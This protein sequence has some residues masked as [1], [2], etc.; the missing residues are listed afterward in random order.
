MKRVWQCD[1][2]SRTNENSENIL[3]HEKT[4]SYNPIMKKCYSCVH[5]G[6]EGYDYPIPT[7]DIKLDV[8]DGEEYGNCKGWSPSNIKEWRKIKLENLK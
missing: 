5:R 7:C 6:D 3:I 1:F 4:C 8:F 2:C